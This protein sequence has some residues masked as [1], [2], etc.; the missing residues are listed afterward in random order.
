MALLTRAQIDAAD[1]IKVEDVPVPEWGGDVRL[2]GLTSR[3]RTTIEATL[4]ASKGE[5]IQV[6]VQALT[7]LRERTVAAAL[8]DENGNR[9]FGD[10]E[11]SNLAKKSGA[12]IQRLYHKVQ[13]LSGMNE[14]AIEE[15]EE[16]LD[17]DQS[18]DS[19]SD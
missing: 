10:K 6:R 17:E 5:S 15:A 12:V 1:D 2:R 16:N 19:D 13:E 8:I 14:K 11:L 18:D 4:V 9:V 3:E 7:T